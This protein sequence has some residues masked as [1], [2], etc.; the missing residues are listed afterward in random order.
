M[1][2]VIGG[3]DKS[4]VIKNGYTVKSRP[5]GDLVQDRV[6]P[7]QVSTGILRGTQGVG[8]EGVNIDASNNRITISTQEAGSVGIGIIPGTTDELGFFATDE[9]GELVWKRVGP[10][11]YDYDPTTGNNIGQSGKLPDGSYNTIYMKPGNDVEDAF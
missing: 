2:T 10:T 3:A 5:I 1:A 6:L 11:A 9:D 8:T 7:R 4:R